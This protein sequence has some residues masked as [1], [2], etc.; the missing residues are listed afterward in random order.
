M[1]ARAVRIDTYFKVIRNGKVY[2]KRENGRV[3]VECLK[4]GSADKHFVPNHEEVT[5]LKERKAEHKTKE[6]LAHVDQDKVKHLEWIYG[7][8]IDIH[9][10]NV[11]VDYMIKFKNIIQNTKD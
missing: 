11:N 2:L 3:Y 8:M 7:R 6:I 4:A 1:T 9:G 5:S 10:E